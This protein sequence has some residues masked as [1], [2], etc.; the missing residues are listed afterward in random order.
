MSKKHQL[1]ARSKALF[2]LRKQPPNAAFLQKM[3]TLEPIYSIKMLKPN[4]YM[5]T[6][7]KKLKSN[8]EK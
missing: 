3:V 7:L 6:H 5:H 8:F 2:C 1:L 4:P